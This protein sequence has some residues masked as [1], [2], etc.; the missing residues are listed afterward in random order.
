MIMLYPEPK[1]KIG[2][3]V[4]VKSET[5][6]DILAV[7]NGLK[8]AFFDHMRQHVWY[9]HITDRQ[10]EYKAIFAE[11]DLE[12]AEAKTQDQKWWVTGGNV[13]IRPMTNC[14]QCGQARIDDEFDCPYCS[15]C[16]GDWRML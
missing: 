10:S 1:F 2:D 15:Y 5:D 6:P 8:L 4:K 14:W 11:D 7:V 9:V 16:S 3:I 13:P 12:P